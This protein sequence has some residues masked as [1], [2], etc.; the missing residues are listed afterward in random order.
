MAPRWSARLRPEARGLCDGR[1]V[2]AGTGGSTEGSVFRWRGVVALLAGLVLVAS[3]CAKGRS[4]G[5]SAGAGVRAYD[6]FAQKFSYHGMPTSIATGNI[7]LNFSNRESFPIV[8]EMIV[9][10]VPSGEG[11]N[12]IIASA[13][14]PGTTAAPLTASHPCVGGDPCELQYLHFGEIDDVFTG[15]THSQV[16]NLP[17][18]NYFFA[19][20]QQGTV[21]NPTG[22]PTDPTHA[23]IGM[24]FTFTVT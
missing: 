23:S 17:P 4:A 5:A 2:L 9:A 3:G 19:C 16:F 7:Q 6:V 1:V 11:R 14:P 15:S 13:K 21:N 8:H 10:A 18:G 22:T 24:V 12:D 20:W